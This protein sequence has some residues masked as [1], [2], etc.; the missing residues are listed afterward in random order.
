MPTMPT[1]LD[2]YV[3]SAGSPAYA[4]KEMLIHSRTVMD[5]KCLNKGAT[6]VVHRVEVEPVR[7]LAMFHGLAPPLLSIPF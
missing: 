6:C 2:V 4:Y 1:A 3:V 5:N 7:L